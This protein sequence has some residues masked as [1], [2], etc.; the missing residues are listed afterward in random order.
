MTLIAA[1]LGKFPSRSGIARVRIF[2]EK[3]ERIAASPTN[4]TCMARLEPA[5]EKPPT[6][7]KPH[8]FHASRFARRGGK[9]RASNHVQ[10][11]ATHCQHVLGHD[12]SIGFSSA[13]QMMEMRSRY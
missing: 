11:P 5:T 10:G 4:R 3:F 1:V 12:R 8:P 13:P 7:M 2:A 9:R 6:R